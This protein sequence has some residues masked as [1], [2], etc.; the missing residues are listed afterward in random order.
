MKIENANRRSEL[1]DNNVRSITVCDACDCYEAATESIVVSAGKF[2]TI[3][4]NL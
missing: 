4:L 1:A 2:G 3:N